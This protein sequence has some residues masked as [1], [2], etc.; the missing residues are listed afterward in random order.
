MFRFPTV[1]NIW[2]RQ[3]PFA[4][5][6]A[7]LIAAAGI[8]AAEPV[9][10]WRFEAADPLGV[11]QGKPPQFNAGPRAPRYPGFDAT[12]R[13][14]SFATG[15]TALVVKAAPADNAAADTTR[16]SFA[17]GDSI[18]LETW[19]RVRTL[20]TGAEVLVVSHGAS[21]GKSTP[22]F[23]LRLRDTEEGVQIG[24][25]F[26]ARN[27]ESQASTS[28]RWWSL[29]GFEYP[30]GWHHIAIA[31]TFGD[32]TSIR[33][34]IDGRAV[35]GGWEGDGPTKF[36]PMTGVGD[37]VIGAGYERDKRDA[38]NGWLDEVALHR[39]ALPA[40]TLTA[41]YAFEPPPLRAPEQLPAGKVLIEVCEQGVAEAGGWPEDGVASETFVEEAFGLFELPQKYVATGVRSERA[42]PSAVRA[43][44]FVDL[45]AGTHRLLLRGRGVSRLLID[46]RL[47]LKTGKP[48]PDIG[49]HGRIAS[50][51]NYL[52]LGPDFR[53]A[54]PGNREAWCTFTS[55]GG[56]HLVVLESMLGG[57]TRRRPELGETV[58]AL[59]P[60]GSDTWSL[61]SPA[62]RHVP[63]NDAG[64]AAYHAE[65]TTHLDRV[66]AAARA[67]KRAEHADYWARRRAAAREWLAATPEIPLPALPKEFPA[68]NAIDHFIG[69]RIAEVAAQSHSGSRDG[70]DFF[71]DVR[72]IFEAKCYSCH[73]GG[74]TKGGLRLD[75]LAAALEGGNADG[76]AVV[77]G[78][79]AES[80]LIHRIQSTDADVVM[81]AKGDP[82][83]PA[84]IALLTRWIAEGARWPE[85]QVA[86]FAL[87]PLADDLPFLRRVTLDT[88]GVVPS[89]AEIAAFLADRAPDRRA[90]VIDRL[91][92]D[93]RWADHNMGYWQDVLAENPNIINS[94][95]NNT[96]PFRWWI[97]ESLLDDKPMDLFVTELL[98]LEGSERFGG[99][100]G[101]GV[102]AQNDAPLAAKAVVVGSAFL[103][104]EMKC[105][106]CHDAPAHVSKQED[107]FQ[108]AALLN[109]KPL[110]LPATS[111]V[112]LEHLRVGG[113]KPLIEVTLQP[114]AVIAPAWPFAEF[115]DERTATAL[116]Q[117]P[118]DSRDLLAAAITAPQNERFAQVIVNRLWERL[119]GRGIVAA[120]GDW[121]KERPSHPELL[122]WLAREL[123]RS[124]YQL[125]SVARLI[126]NSHAYQRAVDPAL[127]DTS[128]LFT[129]PAARRLGAEQ[130]VDSLFAATGKPFAL[131]EVSLDVDSARALTSSISLGQPRRAWMLSS[132]S[133]E[134]DRPSLMLPRIQAVVDVMEA[135]GWRST[136]QDARNDREDEPNMLQLALLANG[137]MSSWLTRLSDDHGMTQLVADNQTLDTLLD[138]V[139]LRLL[140]RPP[141]TAE[142]ASYRAL[143]SPGYETRLV[144]PP[145]SAASVAAKPR[146]PKRY[147]S[148]YNHLDSRANTLRQEEEAAARR[149]DPP[150]AR[151]DPDWRAR[152][153]DVLWALVNAPAWAYMP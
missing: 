75:T 5:V 101:F 104:V 130:I 109:R 10:R 13:A 9:A 40:A 12:N 103:G 121:E 144:S 29:E 112:S 46:G 145:R 81:P 27:P 63:Y 151:I 153:E 52:D 152:F 122:R 102:A 67:A 135:F 120:V 108:L 66:N 54:P 132:T 20:R 11:W 90:R 14:A 97:H 7:A 79:P 39:A 16:L 86:S 64:W 48:L 123:V 68:Q 60:E 6:L 115:C 19:V 114:G 38:F 127:A 82:L 74:K 136:R 119:M 37:L 35:T 106:R 62:G 8:A 69:A 126:L 59:S 125:K 150:T 137:T 134:R 85:F 1:S 72:P 91:L 149:G 17:V 89:E 26:S 41:R 24:F 56:R 21:L 143:L 83:T 23:D 146:E 3:R 22:A 32:P 138:R 30:A 50:Q 70:V 34:F 15:A 55:R 147:V 129:S 61:L 2:R 73:Q 18:T 25:Q 92:A 65:R 49:G 31:Y 96:G 58:V 139:F 116:A 95:L 148:W 36:A 94:T 44:A 45:P 28:H 98:R 84:E 99:P 110:T 107:L 42:S 33:G 43:S 113:R 111:S 133:N 78:K 105:A 47:V 88:V 87:T 77:P 51:D 128:P 53:F 141:S 118:D 76:P 140:T 124:G 80:A 117:R 100:A 57:F 142:R 131:E 71:R 4:G 93:P